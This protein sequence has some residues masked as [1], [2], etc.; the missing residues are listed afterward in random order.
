MLG[1]K[2]KR[3][4]PEGQKE[5]EMETYVLQT[6][7]GDEEKLKEALDM[8]IV[9]EVPGTKVY[10][11]KKK[12]RFR[13]KDGWIDSVKRLFPGYLFVDTPDII[14]FNNR[15]QTAE[16]GKMKRL[17]GVENEKITP[18]TPDEQM[19]I[20]RLC[21][22]KK[23]ADVSFGV[24]DGNRILFTRGPLVGMEGL[25]KR[26]DRHKR[27]VQLDMEFFGSTRTV[28]LAAEIM[29]GVIKTEEPAL[30]RKPIFSS[31][32]LLISDE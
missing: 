25:V 17:L 7:S 14:S 4:G 13:K 15:L 11:L 5:Q 31:L 20:H 6:R 1:A 30:A 9:P 27:I 8:T 24:K 29:N 19:M 3:T 12:V 32:L 21:G 16:I 10:I 23:M 22:D 2:N 26:V 28:T 18:V